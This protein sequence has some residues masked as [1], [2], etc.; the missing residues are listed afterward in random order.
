MI[1]NCTNVLNSILFRFIVFYFLE[2]PNSFG[3]H[4]PEKQPETAAEVQQL[5]EQLKQIQDRA[6]LKQLQTPAAIVLRGRTRAKQ[7]TEEEEEEGKEKIF[8]TYNPR[9]F[10][11]GGLYLDPD[12]IGKNNVF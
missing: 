6:R 11:D 3:L 7:E 5:N 2:R 12:I 1:I 10:C 8:P 9:L 4:T